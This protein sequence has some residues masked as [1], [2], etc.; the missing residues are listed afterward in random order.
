MSFCTAVNCIDGRVQQPVTEFLRSRSNVCYVDMV[1]EAGP[2]GAI[3]DPFD[4]E[5]SDSIFRRVQ[6]SIDAHD[7]KVV[8][9]VAH[10]DCA[11]NPVDDDRQRTQLNDSARGLAEIFGSVTV[12]GLWVDGDGA[13]QEV[14]ELPPT[15]ERTQELWT[16]WQ[17]PADG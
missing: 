9:V 15:S 8:A 16:D 4:S 10:A 6:I 7:S 2:V 12:L 14:C 3:S 11:G 17:P 13:V 1:T 5:I